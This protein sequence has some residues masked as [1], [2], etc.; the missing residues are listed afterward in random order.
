MR[1]RAIEPKRT[2]NAK[3]VDSL[4]VGIIRAPDEFDNLAPAWDRLVNSIPSTIFQTFEWQ[5]TWWQVFGEGNPGAELRIVTLHDD[6]VL[7]AIAPL[8]LETLALIPG[9]TFRRLSFIGREVS[10]YLDVLAEPE[11]S[12]ALSQAIAHHVLADFHSP[13][14]ISLAEI[15]PHSSFLSA[16]EHELRLSRYDSKSFIS[17]HCPKTHLK[18][19]W[20]STLQS[21]S[22]K[23][24]KDISYEI[25]N[26]ERN[27]TVKFEEASDAGRLIP[28]MEEFIALHQERWRVAGHPGVFADSVQAKFHKAVAPVLHARGW[29]FLAFLSLDGKRVAVNYGFK[30]KDTLSTYLN[31]MSDMD[32][33][34]KYSPGKVLHSYSIRRAC[35]LGCSTYDFM[36]GR[37][38]YKY[39]FDAVDYDN[40]SIV[41]YKDRKAKA[42]SGAVLLRESFTRRASQEI[43][44]LKHVGSRH[45][46]ISGRFVTHVLSRVTRNVSDG[47]KKVRSPEQAVTDLR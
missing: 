43:T 7:R 15:P 8:Y 11:Y 26:I 42:I 33:V 40:R 44:M 21:L 3:P 31:G 18:G 29:L 32:G 36:R 30:F 22:R 45:G 39:A 12:A 25:R 9:V 20:D 2:Y 23:H 5:R 41:A 38:R 28:D 14:V 13:D 16:F 19:T 34:A 46:W 27:F 1:S 47:A 10:D 24:R 37:E 4:T 17:A 35:E 6:D